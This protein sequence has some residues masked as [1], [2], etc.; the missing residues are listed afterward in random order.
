[1]TDSMQARFDGGVRQSS[2]SLLASLQH[3]DAFFPSG[4]TSFSWGL[5]SLIRDQ[6]V[7]DAKTCADYIES[8]IVHRWIS[9]DQ[10]IISAAWHAAAT[11]SVNASP[12]EGLN[13]LLEI[14]RF[15]EAMTLPALMRD[16]SRRLGLTLMSLHAQLGTPNALNLQAHI[17]ATPQAV[18]PHLA[19][20]Q[21]YL[22]HG[23]AMT[24]ADARA[25]SAY[26]V[27][28]AAT[29]AAVRL[30]LIGHIDAQRILS[31]IL[32]Q[33]NVALSAP[34]PPLLQLSSS[35][36]STDIATLRHGLHDARLFAN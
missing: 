31:W 29:S 1:M 17:N 19:V 8:Q 10:G 15:A 23:L 7:T 35:I 3:A 2:L 18:T 24:E 14:D 16:G 13:T 11:A 28:S 22:W 33:L 5:E 12:T 26:S 36:F 30:G 20:V 4:A 34:A 21:G 9:F 27:C 25:V 6:M 32:P